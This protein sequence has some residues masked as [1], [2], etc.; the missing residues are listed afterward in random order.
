MLKSSVTTK[1]GNYI[2]N[3]PNK[4]KCIFN[5]FYNWVEFC[6][7]LDGLRNFGGGGVEPPKPPFGTSLCWR[8]STLPSTS[9]LD[10]VG[11]QRHAPAALLPGKGPGTHCIGGWMGPRAVLD[12]CGKSRRPTG[13]RSRAV[14]PVASR[15][16]DYAIPVR[17]NGHFFLNFSHKSRAPVCR[18]D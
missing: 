16:T 9:A 14:Q 6:T 1:N 8:I 12:G 18:G 5:S 2:C 10:G 7:T 3:L 4:C 13:K 17:D 11:S 15:Y